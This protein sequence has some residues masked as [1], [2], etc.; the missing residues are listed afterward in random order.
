[1]TQYG[2][3]AAQTRQQ[4]AESDS[5]AIPRFNGPMVSLIAD[6]KEAI[7]ED[8]MLLDALVWTQS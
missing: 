7:L 3:P 1:M 6:R 2:C 5:A 4:V 8:S